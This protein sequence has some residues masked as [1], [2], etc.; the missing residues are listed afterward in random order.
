MTNDNEDLKSGS[1]EVIKGDKVP[2][3]GTRTVETEPITKMATKSYEPT[4]FEY[5]TKAYAS[6]KSDLKR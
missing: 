3:S 1:K 4:A 5:R 2:K 6:Y